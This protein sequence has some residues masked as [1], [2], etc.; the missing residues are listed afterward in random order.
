MGSEEKSDVLIIF[1]LT[2]GT[3]GD[4]SPPSGQYDLAVRATRDCLD[5]SLFS[6]NILEPT[7]TLRAEIVL[8]GEALPGVILRPDMATIEITDDDCKIPQLT[9]QF[10]IIHL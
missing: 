8:Q 9:S 7:E 6:D 5:I 2:A 10:Y 3:G 1:L 4:Y